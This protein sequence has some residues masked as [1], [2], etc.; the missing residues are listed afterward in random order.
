MSVTIK[1]VLDRN[2]LRKFIRFPEKL[3]RHN[4]YYVP[5]LVFDETNT[6]D[7]SKN[8]GSAFCKSELYLAYKDDQLV[9]RVAAIV[10]EKANE[11]W[12]HK[13][14]R[15]GW[16][17]FIDD[18][19]VSKALIDKVTDFGRKFGMDKIVGPLGFTDFDPEGM[20]VEGFDQEGTMPLIYNADYYPKHIEALGFRKDADWLEYRINIPNELPEKFNRIGEI[21]KERYNLHIRPLTKKYVRKNNYGQKVFDLIN[22]TYKDLYNFTIMPRDL[23]DK[24]LGFYLS[25]LDLNFISVVENENDE[26]VAFGITMPSLTKALQKS[27]GKLFPFGW[28]PILRSMYLKHEEGVE[29]LLIGVRPDYRNAGLTSLLFADMFAKLSKAGFKWAETNAELETNNAIQNSWS[30][31]DYKQNKRRRSYIKDI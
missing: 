28:I 19:E 10:N 3:Y 17:D 23:A 9:G 26:L 29:L 1:R 24:Y 14:V 7:P 6:L 30:G 4:P 20:L 21:I 5:A 31:F 8:P 27:R 13:E 11:Q 22:E 12:D 16:F 25:V 15:F 18:P 2:S